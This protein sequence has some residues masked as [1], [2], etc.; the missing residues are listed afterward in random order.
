[1]RTL[2]RTENASTASLCAERSS[3]GTMGGRLSANRGRER[4]DES[5]PATGRISVGRRD[6][7]ETGI[8]IGWHRRATQ[9]RRPRMPLGE[10][11]VMRYRLERTSLDRAPGR[12]GSSSRDAGS[13]TSAAWRSSR[14]RPF[15]FAAPS[16]VQR[17]VFVHL[18]VRVPGC[19]GSLGLHAR[20]RWG[21]RHGRIR[22]PALNGRLTS[23]GCWAVIVSRQERISIELIAP[24]NAHNHVSCRLP[25]SPGGIVA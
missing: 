18:L 5:E 7:A 24:E 25:Y 8:G 16:F 21:D 19:A 9:P 20:G 13:P 6:P 3:G 15:S 22:G 11:S 10:A 14:E 12:G 4:L 2:V 23:C 17:A 1:M